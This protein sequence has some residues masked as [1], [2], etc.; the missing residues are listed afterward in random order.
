LFSSD[1]I[2]LDSTVCRII[3]IDPEFVPTMKIGKEVGLGTYIED[4]I[5]LLGDPIEGFIDK[6]FDVKREPVEAYKP[7][8]SGIRALRNLFVPKPYIVH[9]KCIRCGVCTQMCPVNPKAVDWHDGNKQ[10]SPYYKYE[11][12]IRCYCCQELC[13][14]SAIKLKVPLIRRI[15]SR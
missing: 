7:G 12:C 5:E 4:E 8:G 2:A 10:K 1:P 3:D 6:Q 9:D 15:F 11:K 13:P 14:E